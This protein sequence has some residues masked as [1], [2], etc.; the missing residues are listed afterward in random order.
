MLLQSKGL[1]FNLDGT[2]QG[3]TMFAPI[4][5]AFSAPL[6]AVCTKCPQP[7]SAVMC[8]HLYS[9]LVIC[10]HLQCKRALPGMSCRQQ[11]GLT[12]IYTVA[13]CMLFIAMHSQQLEPITAAAFIPIWTIRQTPFVCGIVWAYTCLLLCRGTPYMHVTSPAST[14]CVVLRA[15]LQGIPFDLLPHLLL[16]LQLPCILRTCSGLYMD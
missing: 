9:S 12:A 1:Q 16:L 15:H 10:S 7:A 8:S 2:N 3:I 5:S 11:Q 6:L 13:A 14:C 4:N